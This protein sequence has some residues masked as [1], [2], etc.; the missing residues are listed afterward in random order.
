[1]ACK[2]YYLPRS[3]GAQFIF[4]SRI[5]HELYIK[6]R[7]SHSSALDLFHLAFSCIFSSCVVL[8]FSYSLFMRYCHHS[9]PLNQCRHPWPQKQPSANTQVVPLPWNPYPVTF[10]ADWHLQYLVGQCE[11]C[12]T[13]EEEPSA[14]CPITD[15]KTLYLC[16]TATYSRWHIIVPGAQM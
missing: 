5:L 9:C 8:L 11:S 2:P 16:Q 6:P 13:L 3:P 1:M 7:A 14:Y 10:C 15:K 4:F 12:Y